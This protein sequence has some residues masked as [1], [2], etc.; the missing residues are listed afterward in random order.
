VIPLFIAILLV[1][2][3]RKRIARIEIDFKARA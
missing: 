1:I 2:F 3:L